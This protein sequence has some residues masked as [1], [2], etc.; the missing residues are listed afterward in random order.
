[1]P[2]AAGTLAKDMPMFASHAVY[3]TRRVLT[4]LEFCHGRRVIH[5]DVK[6]SNVFRDRHGNLLLG[7][8]GVAA[9]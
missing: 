6:P 7:D 9:G 3:A 2:V 5:G 4:A 1:M 8:F